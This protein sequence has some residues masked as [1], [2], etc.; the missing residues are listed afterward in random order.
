MFKYARISVAVI[1]FAALGS[2]YSCSKQ[3]IN[4]IPPVSS[5]SQDAKGTTENQ[6]EAS[7]N[8]FV[9]A[10]AQGKI[11]DP[12]GQYVSKNVWVKK[13]AKSSR[14]KINASNRTYITSPEGVTTNSIAPC[15]PYCGGGGGNPPPQSQFVKSEG[16]GGSGPI[17]DLK[18]ISNQSGQ[19]PSSPDPGYYQLNSD[20]NKGAGGD[21]IY[22][23]FTRDASAVVPGPEVTRQLIYS[24]GNVTALDVKTTDPL[25][26][27]S[28]P[29]PK[30]GYYPIWR[31]G[32][33]ASNRQYGLGELDINA[34][35]GGDYIWIY[36]TH[37]GAGASIEVGVLSGNSDQIQP[38]SGWTRNGVDLNKGAG[39][40]YIYLCFKPH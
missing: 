13:G 17:Q 18:V 29:K 10:V 24:V 7:W 3:D 11:E 34:N 2:L 8:D 14:P 16:V 22:L 40:D 33:N 32:S 37:G 31:A 19:S 25:L 5:S 21:Y 30:P 12:Y 20:L 1:G 4:P 27:I 15:Y 35:A 23:T 26:F 6:S 28:P 36:Q 39:G 38:P 9:I